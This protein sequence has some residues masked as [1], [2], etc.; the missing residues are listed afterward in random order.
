M[1]GR[2][3]A[4]C[5]PAVRRLVLLREGRDRKAPFSPDGP[6]T[7][8]EIDLIRTDVFVPALAGLLPAAAVKPGDAWTAS[9][10]TVQELTGLKSVDEGTLDCRLEGFS[11]QGARRLARVALTG[12]VRGMSEDG[13]S[14]Q[15]LKGHFL[16]DLEAGRITYVERAECIHALLADMAGE[17]GHIEGR[18]VLSRQLDARPPELTDAGCAESP[19]TRTPTILSS[20]TKMPTLGV[21]F[22]HCAAGG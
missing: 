9:V 6:L 16:F 4:R 12:T 2:K 13:T 18:F 22:L 11:M 5:G 3:R 8:G 14:R 19:W 20:C 21:R 7:W 10:D 1:T 17:V 15:Q